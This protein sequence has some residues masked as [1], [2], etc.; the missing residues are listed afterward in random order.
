MKPTKLKRH[1]ETKHPHYVNKDE[2]F[3]KGH[4]NAFEAQKEYFQQHITV[5]QKALRAL[6]EAS[7]LIGKT[8][9]PHISE[10]LILPAAKVV[11]IMPGEKYS[12]DLK[13]IPL[14]RDTASHVLQ[15]SQKISNCNCWIN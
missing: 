11:S 15:H 4:A 12:N 1:F 6:L 9:K 8:M 5:P 13:S 3:F 7:Y 14:S 2:N 10:S